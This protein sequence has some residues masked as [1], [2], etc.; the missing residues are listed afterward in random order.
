LEE[1]IR[2]KESLARVGEL[3]AGLAHEFRNG[4]ATIHG[5]ARLLDLNDLPVS[6]RPYVQGLRDETQALGEVVTNFLGFAR[7]T[8]LTL[9]TVDL[10]AIVD[11]AAEDARPECRSHGGTIEIHGMFPAVEG[12]EVLLRQAFGNLLRNAVDAC[13]AA[14]LPPAV[15]VESTVEQ[16]QGLVR[17]AVI[18]NGPGIP[19]ADRD[20]IFQPFFTT[21]SQGTGLGLAIVQKIVVSHNGRMTVGAA[22]AGGAILEVVLPVGG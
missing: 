8:A 11:R 12:D 14:G 16:A 9:A 7:P 17:I 13:A 4:L 22:P 15:R 5:Y 2:L 19:D 20:R 18:D 21:K 6:Y 10:R 3:T 1:R